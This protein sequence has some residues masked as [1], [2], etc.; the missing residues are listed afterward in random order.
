MQYKTPRVTVLMPAYNAA[1]YIRE[2]VDSVLQQ[3]F[4]DF[5]LLIINDGST[6]TTFDILKTY[7]DPRIR[8]ETQDN[9]GLVKTLN[10]GL[11]LA[12][13]KWVAR[14]D[15]DD[16]CYPE[17]LQEQIDFLEQHPDY[18]LIGSEADYMDESGN[19]IF[20]YKFRFYEDT[21]IRS[22]GFRY[23]PVIHSAV[24]FSK[25]AVL[26][27]GGYDDHAITFEDHLLWR[28][29][30]AYGK[31]KNVHKS[32]IKV[33][34]NPDSITID[35]K[36]RGKEFLELKARS[37]HSGHVT[38]EDYTKLKEILAKQNF[39]AYKKAAYHSML[40]KK[41]LWN[42]HKPKQARQHLKTA[43]QSMPGK[44][45]PYLLYAISYLPSGMLDYIYN[46][47]KK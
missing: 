30:S 15:A 45:E 35:E 24:M 47:F 39:T 26:D 32:W 44:I 1:A 14:F 43:M 40:G 2:A 34:F 11:Q 25:Q 18:I 37:I 29:L 6:D 33:R 5:E 12:R 16:V 28:N 17:R 23:C 21:E 42:Q 20:T 46:T 22:M 31:M 38:S 19:F 9:L 36:W 13:A 10:K 4:T 8:I 41:F 3:S 27:A 7:T